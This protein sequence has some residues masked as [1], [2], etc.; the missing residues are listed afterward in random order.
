[1][2]RQIAARKLAE[3]LGF[4]GLSLGCWVVHHD[5]LPVL[6]AGQLSYGVA[7]LSFLGGVH[8]GA[9]M[10]CEELPAERTKRALV[11]GVMP[12]LVGVAA[13]QLLIGAGFVLM[14]AAFIVVY[15]VDRRL[16]PW[17]RMPDWFIVLRLKLTCVVLSALAL[18]L[19]AV[20]FRS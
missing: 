1:M 6:V 7:I 18:T 2:S 20:N 15:L 10:L 4:A 14:M 17:Y 11:W 3:L 13:S 9:A 19:V 12:S 5:W 8:W 16:Y